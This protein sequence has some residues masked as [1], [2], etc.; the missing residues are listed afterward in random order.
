M[1]YYRFKKN[2]DFD[3]ELWNYEMDVKS[4]TMFLQDFV[5]PSDLSGSGLYYVE[6][7]SP[8]RIMKRKEKKNRKERKLRRKSF[9]EEINEEII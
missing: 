5:E 3:K 6:V 1:E 4:I 2:L 8:D 9:E 7:C